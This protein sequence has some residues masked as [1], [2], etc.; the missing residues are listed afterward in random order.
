MSDYGAGLVSDASI[1]EDCSLDKPCEAVY[2]RIGFQTDVEGSMKIFSN[3]W[4]WI[5]L[6]WVVSWVRFGLDPKPYTMDIFGWL[7]VVSLL[8]WGV[9]IFLVGLKR[10]LTSPRSDVDTLREMKEMANRGYL[11]RKGG[12]KLAVKLRDLADYL[13][14]AA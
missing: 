12:Q 2:L 8:C 14:R 5:G 4:F 10:G 6:G 9:A 1:C 13:E 3:H 11:G 7:F